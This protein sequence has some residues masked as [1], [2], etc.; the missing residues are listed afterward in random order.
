MT[1]HSKQAGVSIRSADGGDYLPTPTGAFLDVA[2]RHGQ[3]DPADIEAVQHWFSEVLPTLPPDTIE[4]VL[5]ELLQHDGASDD[6]A[7]PR[8][9]PK[10][11]PLPSL[12][13]S[14]A[15]P[16]PWPASSWRELLIRLTSR[17]KGS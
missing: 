8:V 9:Y 2:A 1:P 15:A 14:P 13:S 17:N 16:F 10:G 12:S 3:I 7:T 6:Q 11:V 5:E 4:E